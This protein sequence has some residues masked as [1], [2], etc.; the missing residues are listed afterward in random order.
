MGSI[1]RAWS[2]NGKWRSYYGG[3]MGQCRAMVASPRELVLAGHGG[4]VGG[5]RRRGSRATARLWG[6]YRLESTWARG[7][8]SGGGWFGPGRLDG[9]RTERAGGAAHGGVAWRLGRASGT[10]V[11]VGRCQGAGQVALEGFP[12]SIWPRTRCG[13]GPPAAYGGRRAKTEQAERREME[14]RAY[15]RFLK[16]QGPLGK[17]KI[18]PT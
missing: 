9:E 3:W 13:R 12:G 6:S 5:G 2:S 16:I 7:V 17:L 1:P 4:A 14:V 11:S 18:S 8:A 15:L 10:R